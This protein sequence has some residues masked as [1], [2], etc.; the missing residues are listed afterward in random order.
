M[1]PGSGEVAVGPGG[2]APGGEPGVGDADFDLGDAI[3]LGD[4]GFDLG[5]F[6]SLSGGG[7][8]FPAIFALKGTEGWKGMKEG[9]LQA[10]YKTSLESGVSNGE[11]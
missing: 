2:V 9:G 3:D 7:G 6:L 11:G 8:V 10:R 4:V 5:D 1:A